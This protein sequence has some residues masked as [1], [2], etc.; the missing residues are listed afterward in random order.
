MWTG[1]DCV[2]IGTHVDEDLHH[3]ASTKST[4]ALAG[5]WLPFSFRTAASC[6][7]LLPPTSDD[8]VVMVAIKP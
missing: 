6:L 3:G 1:S 7:G 5:E 4:H 8:L 2:I